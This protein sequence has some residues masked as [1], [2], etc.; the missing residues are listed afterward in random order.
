MT[1]FMVL[2][3]EDHTNS[4]DNSD[5]DQIWQ[6]KKRDTRDLPGVYFKVGFCLQRGLWLPSAVLRSIRTAIVGGV[7]FVCLRTKVFYYDQVLG[8]SV[9]LV[10]FSV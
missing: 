8:I 3:T 10:F 9:G 6:V 5:Q 4:I 7:W 1:L 2:F